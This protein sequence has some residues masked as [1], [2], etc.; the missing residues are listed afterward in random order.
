[1]YL[2]S[3]QLAG[4]KSFADHT[5]IPIRGRMNA[6]VGPNGCGKSNVVDAIRW[7]IGETSAKQLRGQTM[8]DV[9]F[10]GTHARHPMSKASIELLF[11]NSEGRITGEYAQYAEIAI[12]REVERDGTSTYFINGLPVRRRDVVDIFLGTGLGPHSYA[13]IEQGMI[14]RLIEA[15]PEELR[16]YIEE[17]AGISKYRERRRETE[18]RIRHT[19]E[20]LLRVNDIIEE[21]A[22]QLRHLK[23]QVTAAERYQAYQQ[24]EAQLT[25]Q[26]KALEWRSLEQ[27]RHE[28]DCLLQEQNTVYERY[29]A[30]ERSLEVDIEKSRAEKEIIVVQQSS[31][32]K[33]YYGLS[34][35]IARLEQQIKDTAAQTRQW[36]KELTDNNALWEE[37]HENTLG[38]RQQ[39]TTLE[40]ELASLHSRMIRMQNASRESQQALKNT[41]ENRDRWQAIWDAFQEEHTEV[42]S[43]LEVAHTQWEHYQQQR[44]DLEER[45]NALDTQKQQLSLQALQTE[46][47]PLSE[48]VQQL[49][50]QLHSLKTQLSAGAEHITEQRRAHHGLQNDWQAAA[51]EYQTLEAQRASLESLQK[52][53]LGQE[54]E[55]MN[56]WL[57]TKQLIHHPRLGQ[58]LRVNA[59]WELAVETVLRN[60][61]DAIC[62]DHL[63]D[64]WEHITPSPPGPLTL[65]EKSSFS[66]GLNDTSFL[67]ASQVNSDWPFH[68]WLTGIYIADHW[69]EAKRRRSQLQPHESVITREGIWLGPHWLRVGKAPTAD[70][71]VL[72]R[73]RTLL[74]LKE[75]IHEV[76]EKRNALASALAASETQ[77]HELERKRD[78]EQQHYQ[79]LSDTLTAIQAQFSAKQMHLTDVEQRQSR[80]QQALLDIDQRIDALDRACQE[81]QHQQKHWEE[82]QQHRVFRRST[83]LSERDQLREVLDQQRENAERERQQA[84]ECEM[85]LTTT[86]NQLELLRQTVEHGERQLEQ[87]DEHKKTLTAKLSSHN[88]P[89]EQMNQALQTC[90][91]KRLSVEQ[92]LWVV[93]KTLE[94][95][96]QQLKALETRWDS[97]HKELK[98]VQEELGTLRIQHQTIAVRQ[99]TIQEALVGEGLILTEILADL[100]EGAETVE[101]GKQLQEISQQIERLGP[102]N[103]AAVS[104]CET[105]NERKMYLDKQQQDLTEALTLL[106][107]AI[108]KIDRE[109]RAKFRETFDQINQ[110]FQQ[111]F[112]SIFIGGQAHLDL[113]EE[114]VL[115]TGVIVRAQPPG[116]RNV[117]IH[118]L[119]GGEKALTAIALVFAMFQLNPAPFCVLDEVD[120]PLDDINV[121]RFCH[122]VKTMAQDIQFLMISHNK[123]TIE[124][125]D[126]LMGVTMQEPGIS[127]I[128]SVDM[129]QAIRM[130]ETV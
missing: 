114:D 30:E 107:D 6:I 63:D 2:K 24:R 129:E 36:E 70:S 89:W 109:T 81:A 106:Q 49:N 75:P 17:A 128:V 65:L 99:T 11:E 35:E 45:K 105:L 32:Q 38:C 10:N 122:I 29:M 21:L 98:A 80:L 102:V 44:R 95:H 7:V 90:L 97:L 8:S 79:E 52:A 69:E 126:H 86:K 19:Q 5:A 43:Q 116:K 77:L 64:Y 108:R 73:E 56:A 113:T 23:R 15:K 67:L 12:R 58:H 94:Q 118:M 88:A 101:W 61:F 4:F 39:I 13:I 60:Y 25:A 9:I 111:L 92:S 104:E 66:V 22:K 130:V 87:L 68:A 110:K 54:N 115:M 103:L 120:A 41:E 46:I 27:K 20:N 1:M 74:A 100:P 124:M 47:I 42:V 96:Q 62:I 117:T 40:T 26:M 51:Q 91:E 123:V 121:G 57:T 55:S 31:V 93:E 125:A 71:S 78:A 37:L 53:A 28:Q 127:R 119:S 84:S 14:S 48:R 82:V 59:G 85:R 16:V 33:E 18:T 76:Q 34:A 72:V 3:I 83:L 112:P 50:Q